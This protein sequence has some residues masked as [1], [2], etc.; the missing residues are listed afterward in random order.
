MQ[1]TKNSTERSFETQK[2]LCDYGLNKGVTLSGQTLSE[3]S[4]KFIRRSNIRLSSY[5]DFGIRTP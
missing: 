4:L 3:T 1:N 2:I 5:E